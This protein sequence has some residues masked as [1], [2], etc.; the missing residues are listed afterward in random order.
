ML[1]S[2]SN[3]TTRNLR[4]SV[5]MTARE[6]YLS[7]PPPGAHVVP[8]ENATLLGSSIGKVQIIFSTLQQKINMLKTM[9][10]R[11][12]HR[13]SHDAIRHSFAIPKLLYNLRTSPCFLLPKLNSLL[14]SIFSKILNIDL[15]E[16]DS[17]WLQVT[18]SQEWRYWDQSCYS[19]CSFQLQPALT[20]IPS[21]SHLIYPTSPIL[22]LM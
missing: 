4:S 12:N 17:A 9:G 5:A 15:D 21:F 20:C 19:T 1:N 16:D 7:A 2:V 14:R 8:P 6:A 22:I 18:S 10:D 13:F 3:L 11:L